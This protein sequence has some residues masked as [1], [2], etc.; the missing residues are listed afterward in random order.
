MFISM[1]LASPILSDVDYRHEDAHFGVAVIHANFGCSD[2][3]L[4]V[5]FQNFLNMLATRAANTYIVTSSQ[6]RAFNDICNN[7]LKRTL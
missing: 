4:Q 6:I 1:Y 2:A 5:C 7:D 3:H